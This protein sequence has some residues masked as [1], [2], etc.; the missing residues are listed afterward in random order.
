MATLTLLYGSQNGDVQRRL[1][2]NRRAAGALFLSSQQIRVGPQHELAVVVLRGTA[3][4]L[5]GQAEDMLGIKGILHGKMV[6]T[7][8]SIP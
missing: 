3:D 4:A 6:M 5:R 8:A 2:E 1:A 7:S